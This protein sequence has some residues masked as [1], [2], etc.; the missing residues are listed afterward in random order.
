MRTYIVLDKS[1]SPT[2]KSRIVV[3]AI[4]TYIMAAFI[5]TGLVSESRI[6]IR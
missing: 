5:L 4:F 2:R 1:K 6:T 3:G